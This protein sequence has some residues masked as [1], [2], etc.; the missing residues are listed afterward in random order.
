M[1]HLTVERELK[2]RVEA[3]RRATHGADSEAKELKARLT[4]LETVKDTFPLV[5]AL[6]DALAQI[7]SMAR[8]LE[9]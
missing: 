5:P 6:T 1:L 4:A 8:T 9:R 7:A 2:R 3:E